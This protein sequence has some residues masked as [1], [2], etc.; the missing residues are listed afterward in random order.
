MLNTTFS[1]A[2]VACL[3][4]SKDRKTNRQ[5]G[6]PRSG[7]TV[8]TFCEGNLTLLCFI[9]PCILRVYGVKN[10]RVADASVMPH[11][12]TANIQSPCYMIGEKAVEMIKK[13]W[14]MDN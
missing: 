6:C 13:Y 9:V 7:T 2:Y 5:M 3:W 8:T 12:T 14:K 1:Q 11:V 10:L 4:D